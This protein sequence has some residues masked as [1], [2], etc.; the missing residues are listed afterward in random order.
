MLR[1]ESPRIKRKFDRRLSAISGE[2]VRRRW[3][4][5]VQTLRPGVEMLPPHGRRIPVC[6]PPTR[7][8]WQSTVALGWSWSTA[9]SLVGPW[10][11]LLCTVDRVR[12][13]V[14]PLGIIHFLTI[15][16]T[17]VILSDLLNAT[18]KFS[19]PTSSA[20]SAFAVLL[21]NTLY[22]KCLACFKKLKGIASI[23]CQIQCCA[24]YFCKVFKIQV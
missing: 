14:Y 18:S 15:W 16:M 10:R 13:F 1:I 11:Q 24:K 19:S 12:T 4:D 5:P 9:N 7:R 23:V 22:K 3:P 21:Q 8:F 17:V 20:C 6:M 2:M